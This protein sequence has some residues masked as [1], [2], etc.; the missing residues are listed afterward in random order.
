MRTL[1]YAAMS[2]AAIAASAQGDVLWDTGAPHPVVFNGTPTYLGY[3]S[4]T[5]GAGLEQRWA[6]VP[7]RIP[8]G[9]ATVTQI[10]VDYFIAAGQE[11]TGVTF[12]VW[13]RAGLAAPTT[14]VTSFSM[15]LAIPTDDPRIPAADLYLN[16]YSGLS[17]ALAGGDYYLTVYGDGDPGVGTIAWLTGG[18]LQDESLEQGFMWRSAQFPSPGFQPYNPAAIQP[19]VGQDPDDPWNPSMTIYGDPIPAPASLALL[20]IGAVFARRRR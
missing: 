5:A 11:P 14:M 8:A 2:C 17:L 9:G 7:F 3:T 1:M 18:D 10:D 13:D 16:Q 20:G 4:G 6:A 19:D 12:V 15:P